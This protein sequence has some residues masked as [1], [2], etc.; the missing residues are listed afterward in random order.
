[1]VH[2]ETVHSLKKQISLV[3][4]LPNPSAV[5]QVYRYDDYY[6]T[7]EID[8]TLDVRGL[9]ENGIV[10]WTSFVE[11]PSVVIV[12]VVVIVVVTVVVTVVVKVVKVV[13]IVLVLVTVVTIVLV[14]LLLTYTLTIVM[15]VV[16]YCK[17]FGKIAAKRCKCEGQY[18]PAGREI[19]RGGDERQV[20]STTE[21]NQICG[22]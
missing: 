13:I 20:Y 12:I 7:E 1:M 17:K 16:V 8:S 3:N 15:N 18:N 2:R 4:D 19:S 21:C 5:K 9:K 22:P 10:L 14:T 6:W 11:L